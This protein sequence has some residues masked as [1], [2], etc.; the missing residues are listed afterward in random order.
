MCADSTTPSYFAVSCRLAGR[1]RGKRDLRSVSIIPLGSCSGGGLPGRT[2]CC[3]WLSLALLAISRMPCSVAV[4]GVM[5]PT[6][7]NLRTHTQVRRRKNPGMERSGPALTAFRRAGWPG[8]SGP[9][10]AP[11]SALGPAGAT[12]EDHL[13]FFARRARRPGRCRADRLPGLR[14]LNGH[15]ASGLDGPSDTTTRLGL[16]CCTASA[17]V[18]Q[19]H[20]LT[21]SIFHSQAKTCYIY[22]V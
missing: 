13:A 2:C 19:A 9:G 22:F 5:L 18:T 12:L 21:H 16:F 17:V 8:G 11:A 15:R 20:T 6:V 3:R 1:V 14:C 4:S 10:G 7:P